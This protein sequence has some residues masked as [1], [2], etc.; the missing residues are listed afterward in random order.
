MKRPIYLI[1]EDAG[2]ELD[3]RILVTLRLI[4]QG[5]SVVIGQQPLMMAN[6]PHLPPGVVMFKGLNRVQAVAMQDARRFGHEVASVDEEALGLASFKMMKRDIHP[7]SVNGTTIFCNNITHELA[8]KDVAKK[9]G[10][11]CGTIITG[12]ARMDLCS[13]DLMEIREI[14]IDRIR[15]RVGQPFTLVNTNC[16]AANPGVGD[17]NT[18]RAVC[19]NVGWIGDAEDDTRMFAEHV[20]FDKANFVQLMTFAREAIKAGHRVIV[21]PHPAEN[22]EFWERE[23]PRGSVVRPGDGHHLSW[24]Y[25]SEVLVHTG[26]TT[27]LEAMAMGKPSITIRHLTDDGQDHEWSYMHLSNNVCWPVR[28]WREALQYAAGSHHWEQRTGL[29]YSPKYSQRIASALS[30]LASKGGTSKPV[31]LA[32]PRVDRTPYIARKCQVSSIDFA[33]RVVTLA[34]AMDIKPPL[35]KRLGEAVFLTTPD[36]AA[37]SSNLR[38][39]A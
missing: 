37:M 13:P 34:R 5:D 3:A 36:D 7:A 33:S 27:G 20:R 39:V 14:E 8:V 30:G 19:R 12:N 22:P 17:I 31:M 26:C 4:E 16:G 21:R 38:S 2:R 10:A 25:A 24:I 23:L 9:N 11:M 28:D 32:V 35:I 18:Y 29:P 15:A 1:V 6:L